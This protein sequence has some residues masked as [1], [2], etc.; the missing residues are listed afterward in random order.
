[1]STNTDL[2]RRIDRLEREN[3]RFK[4]GAGLALLLAL[5]T[6]T[7]GAALQG[8]GAKELRAERFVLVDGSGAELGQLATDARGGPQLLLRKDT[9]TA[10][11]TLSGPGLLL[12]GG[13]LGKQGAFLGIDTRGATRLELSSARVLDGVRLSVQPD[14]A[15]GLYVL[16]PDGRERLALETL[17][18][19]NAHLLSRDA[20]GKVRAFFGEDAHGTTSM[21]LLDELGRRRVGALVDASGTP[22]LAIVDDKGRT[23][24]EMTTQFDGAPLFQVLREDGKAAFRQP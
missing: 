11:L 19:G 12:R 15:S 7:T 21:L 22:L 1:M 24:I 2:A 10:L 4:I 9:N 6:W 17:A 3:R 14:G 16:S 8:P 20:D 18:D 23:R 5:A 13:E